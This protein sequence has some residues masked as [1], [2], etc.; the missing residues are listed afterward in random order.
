MVRRSSV[1]HATPRAAILELGIG[2]GR[3]RAETGDL[4]SIRVDGQELL[5]EVDTR[6]GRNEFRCRH[7]L[8]ATGPDFQ[9]YAA[10]QRFL[11]G[12]Q[13]DG[14]IRRIRSVSAS[15]AT[16]QAALSPPPEPQA[17][18]SSSPDRPLAQHWVS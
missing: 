14:F 13:R 10:H 4:M 1:P 15:L 2:T 17:L 12:M 9:D 7:I 18:R 3:V 8:L 5:A 16:S 6:R 11:L